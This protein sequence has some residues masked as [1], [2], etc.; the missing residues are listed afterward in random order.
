MI[1]PSFAKITFDCLRLQLGKMAPQLMMLDAPSTQNSSGEG[2]YDDLLSGIS[3]QA[4]ST[5]AS[6]VAPQNSTSATSQ[7][8]TSTASQQSTSLS[9]YTDSL[10]M[11]AILTIAI[12]TTAAALCMVACIITPR[13][14]RWRTKRPTRPAV[15]VPLDPLYTTRGIQARRQQQD[16]VQRILDAR[17]ES[18]DNHPQCVWQNAYGEVREGEGRQRFDYQPWLDRGR[19]DGGWVMA[20]TLSADKDGQESVGESRVSTPLP[21]Y[22]PTAEAGNGVPK[23]FGGA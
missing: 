10:S 14:Y 16:R 19:R 22:R 23:F 20:G 15:Q 12:L 17:D 2:S 7:S 11:G 9:D 18:H 1:N 6:V 13:K 5:L 8:T 3:T 21:A 4:S